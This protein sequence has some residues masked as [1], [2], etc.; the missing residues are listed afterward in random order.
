MIRRPEKITGTS[1]AK[2]DYL[3]WRLPIV[4]GLVAEGESWN[5]E[6]K[7]LIK[8]LQSSFMLWLK[9]QEYYQNNY[10]RL[11][12]VDEDCEMVSINNQ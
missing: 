2:L 12:I 6:T 4:L 10:F 5:E 11:K 8:N 1:K 7:E 9:G 3:F